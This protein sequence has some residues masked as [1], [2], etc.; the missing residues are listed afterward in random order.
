MNNIDNKIRE[1]NSLEL[2]KR[3][4]L[5]LTILSEAKNSWWLFEELYNLVKEGSAS[6]IE[7]SNIYQSA[8]MVL[9]SIDE[10][11]IQESIKNLEQARDSLKESMKREIQEREQEMK[12]SNILLSSLI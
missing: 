8:I 10:T 11:T 2:T 6:E 7:L 5:C 4:E 12:N 3:Q 1:F 9:D